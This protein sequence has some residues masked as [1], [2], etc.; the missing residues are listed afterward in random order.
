MTKHLFKRAILAISILVAAASLLLATEDDDP[1]FAQW[2][3]KLA[4]SFC[5]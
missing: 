4:N 2:I 1:R 3:E 5:E